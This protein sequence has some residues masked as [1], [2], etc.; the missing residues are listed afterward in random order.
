MDDSNSSIPGPFPKGRFS[1]NAENEAELWFLLCFTRGPTA[2]SCHFVTLKF[3][4]TFF[5]TVV[6]R[7]TVLEE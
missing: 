6:N 4:A 7:K 1:T 2:F 5:T 3:E